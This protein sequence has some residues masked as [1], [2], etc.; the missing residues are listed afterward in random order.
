MR[1]CSSD[2]SS[3]LTRIEVHLKENEKEIKKL[4][5]EVEDM[6]SMSDELLSHNNIFS[7]NGDF[8]VLKNLEAQIDSLK[9]VIFEFYLNL[10]R[11]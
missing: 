11:N 4:K 8:S 1:N 5:Q 9:E 3:H 2:G 7:T 10:H 6:R